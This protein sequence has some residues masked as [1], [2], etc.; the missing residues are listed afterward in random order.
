[1]GIF[2]MIGIY[3]ITSPTNKVY[4]GQSINI[5]ERITTYKRNDCKPQKALYSSLL[6]YG[7]NNHKFEI[8]E[9]CDI[10]QLNEK[11]RYYQ[12][13][14]QAVG[15][16]GLN[17]KLTTTKDRS[18]KLSEETLKKLSIARKGHKWGVGKKLSEETKI[19]ISL[20]N[21]GRK[22]IFSDE[23][24]KNLSIAL[25]NIK[26]SE[27]EIERIKEEGRKASIKKRRKC[28]SINDC[29]EILEVYNSLTE[30]AIKYNFSSTGDL[31]KA[32]KYNWKSKGVRWKYID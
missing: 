8:L 27:K 4:I 19:K 7:F 11:E 17:L 32:I 5:K 1:M 18:G 9:L 28:A 16:N 24:K 20:A 31:Y 6:K 26:K 30:A 14:Y 2:F 3:K 12:D 25:N 22:I 15:K 13:L 23:H 21:K 29:G 10:E